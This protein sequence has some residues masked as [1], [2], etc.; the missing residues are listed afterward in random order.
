MIGIAFSR[1]FLITP[2]KKLTHSVSEW[3][4]GHI[5]TLD[6]NKNI[7]LEIKQL[8]RSFLRAT[9]HLNKR[10]QE[11]KQSIQ[12]QEHLIHEIHHRVKNNLQ[13]IASLLNLHANRVK[14][15]EAQEEFRL[16]RDRVRAISSMHHHLYENIE[17]NHLQAII[18]IPEII[19]NIFTPSNIS[20]KYNIKI[21]HDIDNLLIPTSQASPITLIITEA[22][23]NSLRHAFP[24]KN[25]GNIFISFKR[26]NRSSQTK[27]SH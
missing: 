26:E 10:E 18:F 21:H 23:S 8:E 24:D 6:K 25:T 4:T 11:L 9:R 22:L 1:D 5:F 14:S 20:K 15:S 3:Q 2:L 27:S 7:P 13:V 12:Q 16:V 19:N 17:N